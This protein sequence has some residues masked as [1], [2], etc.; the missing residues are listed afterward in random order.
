MRDGRR[1]L[2]IS[3][4][5]LAKIAAQIRPPFG[6]GPRLNLRQGKGCHPPVHMKAFCLRTDRHEIATVLSEPKPFVWVCLLTCEK[7]RRVYVVDA[8]PV[9]NRDSAPD[10]LHDIALEI[11]LK[12]FNRAH[13]IY[14]RMIA[15]ATPR[16]QITKLRRSH[17]RHMRF[18]IR[19][20]DIAD[21]SIASA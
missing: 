8:V 12:Q 18:V 21:E 10:L 6:Q 3:S 15:D 19:S 5:A 14:R 16:R 1:E 20:A 2:P 7:L 9:E 4:A 11:Q 13:R 17:P